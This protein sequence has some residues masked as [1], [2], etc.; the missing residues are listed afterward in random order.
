MFV[1]GDHEAG[2]L[3]CV[4]MCVYLTFEHLLILRTPHFDFP[5]HFTSSLANC[6]STT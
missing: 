1:E 2:V 3:L 6:L 4:A 5:F